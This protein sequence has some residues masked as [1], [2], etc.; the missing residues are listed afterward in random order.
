MGPPLRPDTQT[1]AYLMDLLANGDLQTTGTDNCTF[2]AS[3]KALG[4]DNFTKIPNGVNGVEDRMSIVWE[5]GVVAGKMDPCKFVAVTSTNAAKIFNIY[6]KKGRIA[7]GSDADIVVWNPHATRT[8]SAQTHHQAVDFNI[9]EGMEVHGIA[10]YV[11]CHGR[12]CVEEG[13]IR[14]VSGMGKFVPTLPF[15]S[16]VYGRVDERDRANA[17]RKVERAA[18]DGPVTR[19]NGP[20]HTHTSLD[21]HIIPTTAPDFYTRGPTKSGGLNLHD[22]SFHVS[23]AQVSDKSPKRP[24]VKV[25][26]PPGGKASGSFW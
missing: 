16:H 5:K 15:A 18:Y 9:F 10:D 3:Q 12:V 23:G 14:V 13:N 8:I 17:P 1:P 11:I 24:S 7:V 6:P 20:T 19:I 21:S 26:N 4:K 25:N 22:S 2:S